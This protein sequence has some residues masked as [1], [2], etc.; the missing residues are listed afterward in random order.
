MRERRPKPVMTK[1]LNPSTARAR[2]EV[3]RGEELPIQDEC[4][5]GRI[6]DVH[7]HGS[8]QGGAVPV[9]RAPEGGYGSEW[10]INGDPRWPPLT[11]RTENTWKS[12][13][14]FSIPTCVESADRYARARLHSKS[15]CI[16]SASAVCNDLTK[17]SVI[18]RLYD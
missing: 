1:L 7:D 13:L 12:P 14:V 8:G 2:L 9:T 3:A 10:Q 18:T 16:G 6:L 15:T 17:R 5:R 4:V 11:Q